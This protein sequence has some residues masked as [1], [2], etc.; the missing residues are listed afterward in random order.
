VITP[1]DALRIGGLATLAFLYVLVVLR[2]FELDLADPAPLVEPWCAR[3]LLRALF[4]AWPLV[5]V[6]MLLESAFDRRRRRVLDK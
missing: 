6:Y 3:W 5:A 2:M 1:G 4:L